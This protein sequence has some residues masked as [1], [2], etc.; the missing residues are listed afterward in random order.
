MNAIVTYEG[1][2]CFK[3]R[4]RDHEIKTDLPEE[5]GGEDAFATPGELFIASL[6]S[7]I[8][9]FVERYLETAKLDPKGLSINLEVGFDAEKKC[10]DQIR[11]RINVPGA[12][13]GGR[14]RA[15]IAA[16]EHCIIHNTIR[17]NPEITYEIEGE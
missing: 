2:K 5:K 17:N 16:A 9:L 11:V 3:T 10:Y 14:K 6:G 4:I 12:K 13:L 15:V 7:C 1:K 8:S